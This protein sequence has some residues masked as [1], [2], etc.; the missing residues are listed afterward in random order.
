MAADE[1]RWKTSRLAEMVDSNKG[2]ALSELA[3]DKELVEEAKKAYAEVGEIKEKY[4]DYRKFRRAEF[5]IKFGETVRVESEKY[6]LPSDLL[7]KLFEKESG[8]DP[9]RKNGM[10]S[11]AYGL[12]Q[13]IDETWDGIKR[14]MPLG[15]TLNRHDPND[16]IKASAFY[17]HQLKN[18]K[19]CSW[20]DAIVYY[21]TGP[22]FSNTHVAQA[23]RLN[24]VIARE[25]NGNDARAY[26]EAARKYY[27]S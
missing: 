6:G 20:E 7:I 1:A 21:H 13:I 14:D 19:G 15:A 26:V 18:E 17:L 4:A 11:S 5:E 3:D 9:W 2:E 27:L 23:M 24:P 25:M 8:F 10:G 22:N 12:G 16:Q